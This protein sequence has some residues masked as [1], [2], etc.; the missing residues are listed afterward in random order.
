[1]STEPTPASPPP[2]T[3]PTGDAAA[4]SVAPAPIDPNAIDWSPYTRVAGVAAVAGVILYAVVGFLNLSEAEGD[5]DKHVAQAR[6][7]SAYLTGFTYWLSLPLGGMTL[8][9]IGYLTKTSWGLL[10]RR[11]LEAASRT[12]PLLAVLFIPL[13]VSVT[14]EHYSPYWWSAP[15]ATPTP[16][17]VNMAN[18][19]AAAEGEEK[20]KQ[21][22]VY[23]KYM[24][25]KAVEHE[26]EARDKGNFGFLSVK[27]FIGVGIVLFAIWGTMIT[28]LNK[29]SR[30]AEGTPTQVEAALTK[31]NKFSGPGIIVY[32]ITITVGAT[33]WVMS[34]EPGWSSTMFP[35]IFA[36][37][38]VPHGTIDVRR[39][40]CSC[41]I[42]DKAPVQGRSC[43]PSS[44]STWRR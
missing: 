10:L 43:G 17:D 27:S 25:A 9:M 37:N 42:A 35:V 3:P 22:E 14:S 11:P 5:H 39:W 19:G 36:V 24:I 12:W 23:G 4:T 8:L 13:A 41:V 1:M 20:R 34:V 2:P 18:P 15:H 6:F 32:A 40:R 7:A 33:Q 29:W 30:E 38:T 26:R 44:S 28:I 31:L 16:P 21:A